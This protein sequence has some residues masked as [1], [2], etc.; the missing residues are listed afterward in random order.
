MTEET[1][2]AAVALA[3]VSKNQFL[4]QFSGG[5]PLLQFPLIRKVVDFVE[6]NHVNAQMQIQT[7]GALLMKDI[8]KWLFDHHVGIGI[9]CDGRPELMNSLRVSKDGDRSS[10]KVIQA[11]QNLGESN[12]EAGITC[13]VTD[14]TVEQ[15]DGIVDMAY[16][17]GNVH[18]IGFDILRE[19]GRGKGLRAPT[20]EQMEK[21]LE[22]TAKKMDMLEEITGKHI[23]FT[24][25][26]R[27]RMLQ[28]TGK[29]EFPQ[30]FAMNGEA[31]FVDVHGI[32]MPVLH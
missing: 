6:K 24:Q 22:R 23:H 9:S 2:I 12:I 31:A 14:D 19:Q 20:A 28:R 5:E 11:F 4:L 32:F 25:E 17:Y 8:G 30:C 18:Q 16:F 21:A 3:H 7:N 13:V 29:Y 26:D 1:A 15:L 10:Q 27:V